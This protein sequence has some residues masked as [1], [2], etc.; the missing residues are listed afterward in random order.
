[1]I[2]ATFA[3]F[4]TALSSLRAN[5]QALNVVGQNL[6][7]MNTEGYTRQKL[8]VSSVNYENPTSFYMNENESNVGFGVST[9]AIVQL[10]DKFLDTQYREQNGKNEYSSTIKDSLSSLSAFLDETSQDGL[11][12][13]FDKIQEALTK[14]QDPSAVNDPVYEGELRSRISATATLFNSADDKIRTAKTNEYNKIDGTSSSEN[15]YVDRVNVLLQEIGDLNVQIRNNQMVGNPALELMDQ[16][17]TKID[18]LS[19][20]IPIEVTYY[21][22]KYETA[23]GT[24]RDRGLNYDENGN[25]T[26]RTS[27]PE[28]CRIDLVYKN[29]DSNGIPTEERI[30][31]VNGSTTTDADGN[32]VK[33]Y[34]SLDIQLDG[35]NAYDTAG[36]RVISYDPSKD[37]ADNYQK[38][39][40]TFHRAESYN[41]SKMQRYYNLASEQSSVQTDNYVTDSDK[42]MVRLSSGSLQASL[43]MLADSYSTL[44]NGSVYRS[45]DYY[46]QRL[47]NLAQ[48]FAHDF[49]IF[50]YM[51]AGDH[52]KDMDANG[53]QVGYDKTDEELS[54][55]ESTARTSTAGAPDSNTFLLLVNGNNQTANGITA[56]T[57]GVSKNWV[58]GATHVGTYGDPKKN[59]S[60]TDSVLNMLEAM[61]ASHQNLS[62]KTYADEMNSISTYCAN[63]AYNNTSASKSNQAILDGIST[64]KD[65]ISGVSLDE[66]ATNMMTYTQSYN[67]AAKLM[68]TLDEVLQTLLSIKG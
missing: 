16:R 1:M 54:S 21:T 11:R 58:S 49:N 17:N 24:V 3:G 59:N 26:T 4:T 33:N 39:Q 5:Q 68:S 64:S 13:S 60:S 8:Q 27:W 41:D 2:R 63:D 36:N 61:S 15:G 32:T 18:E 44:N 20:Y 31:L 47:N 52:Y 14:M 53:N 46:T 62:N 10:R 66:E 9:D 29:Y 6:S 28:D 55:A 7:N 35:K 23:D 34:G 12:T 43:D 48:N 57:I 42:S 45:Y 51:G 50:N 22:E 19:G 67:A 30:N 37:S 38:V 25:A 65:Q 56:R 40:V